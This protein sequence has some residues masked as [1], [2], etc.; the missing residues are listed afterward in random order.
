MYSPACSA[1]SI[2]WQQF[3]TNAPE[4]TYAPVQIQSLFTH[5]R[6]LI[7]GFIS[8]CTQVRNE[9]NAGGNFETSQNPHFQLQGLIGGVRREPQCKPEIAMHV[10]LSL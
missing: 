10:N 8:H 9:G 1:V 3:D 4:L 7:Y 5:E 2:K 6:L